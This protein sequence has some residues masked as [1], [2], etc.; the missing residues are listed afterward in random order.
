MK[1]NIIVVL[2]IAVL[3][4]T[5]GGAASA[6]NQPPATPQE[7]PADNMELVKQKV[8]TDKKLF[9]A[10]NMEL[11]E[12]QA[13]AFWP[14]YEKYQAELEKSFDRMAKLI[15]KYADNYET[16]TDEMAKKIVNEWF[17]IEEKELKLRSSYL[18]KFRKVLPEI[19][20]ARYFQLESKITA[21]V[22]YAMAANIPLFK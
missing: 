12:A 21:I 9:I 11:T 6:Q 15:E 16:L 5:M 17:E 13:E 22:D 19:K 4:F 3:I 7:Q 10:E 20:V 14:V 18:P 2:W 8:R 1:R